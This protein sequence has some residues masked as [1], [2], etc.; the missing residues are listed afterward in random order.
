[1][2][3]YKCIS[4]VF[5]VMDGSATLAALIS[6]C[7]IRWNHSTCS[8]ETDIWYDKFE[9]LTNQRERWEPGGGARH[10]GGEAQVEAGQLLKKTDGKLL[11]CYL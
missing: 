11:W 3:L 10:E 5:T 2:L 9:G 7:T 4:Y 8:N 1:M 6:Y